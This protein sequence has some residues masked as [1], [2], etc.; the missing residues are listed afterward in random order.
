MYRFKRMILSTHQG[1]V[2]ICALLFFKTYRVSK[3]K[4]AIAKQPLLDFQAK[5]CKALVVLS[6]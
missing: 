3:K 4:E 2:R 5:H 1:R 6:S